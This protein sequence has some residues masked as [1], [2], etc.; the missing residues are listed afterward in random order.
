MSP[1]RYIF[2]GAEVYAD[3]DKYIEHYYSSN[4]T[5]TSSSEGS[6]AEERSTRYSVEES[7]HDEDGTSKPSEESKEHPTEDNLQKMMEWV[8]QKSS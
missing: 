6:E 4:G 3:D 7:D 5:S 1:S 2:P 8:F